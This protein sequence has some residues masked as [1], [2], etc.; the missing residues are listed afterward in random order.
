MFYVIDNVWLLLHANL[1]SFVGTEAIIP[2]F[3]N[4]EMISD[5]DILH[6]PVDNKIW[7]HWT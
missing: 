1:S 6:D 2:W 7:R 3:E 4:M 5:L